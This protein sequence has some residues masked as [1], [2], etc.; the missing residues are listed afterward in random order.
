MLAVLLAGCLAFGACQSHYEL[1]QVSRS[2]VLIDSRFDGGEGTE[3]LLSCLKQYTP[4][5]DSV[6]GPVVGQ[7]ACNMAAA[8]PESNLSNLLADILVW[9]GDDYGEKA[10]FSVYNMGGIRAALSKGKV[11]FGD[12]LD[13][14]PFE[15]KI[16]FVTLTGK[17]VMHLFRQIAHQRG[18]GVSHGVELVINKNGELLSSRLHGQ[19]IDEQKSYRVAT[20]DYLAQGNDGMDAF[21]NGINLNSPKNETNNTRYLIMRYFQYFLAQGKAVDAKVEGRVLMSNE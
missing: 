12:V 14:A 3:A 19:A 15:N 9:A 2:R 7:A 17:E 4:K 16:C 1:S 20:I 21:K 11:T 13:V 6:M 18:E 8:R 5:V 10:D